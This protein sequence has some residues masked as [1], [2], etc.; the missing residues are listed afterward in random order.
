METE[1]VIPYGD[2]QVPKGYT[3]PFRPAPRITYNLMASSANFLPT[4]TSL[5]RLTCSCTFIAILLAFLAF[6]IS[7]YFRTLWYPIDN[8][9]IATSNNLTLFGTIGRINANTSN[10]IIKDGNNNLT[11]IDFRN[12]AF[13]KNIN[14]GRLTCY[15]PNINGTRY[16]DR[17]RFQVQTA[18]DGKLHPAIMVDEYQRTGFGT[19][20]PF[21][22]VDINGT[23]SFSSIP[24]ISM[25]ITDPDNIGM[26]IGNQESPPNP[27]NKKIK[28][29]TLN[30]KE[31]IH[32]NIDNQ[33]IMEVNS[34]GVDVLGGVTSTTGFTTI[35]DANIKNK[36]GDFNTTLAKEILMQL[37]IIEFTIKK[38]YAHLFHIDPTTVYMG[39][40]AQNA[41]NL[42]PNSVINSEI[43][44]KDIKLVNLNVIVFWLLAAFQEMNK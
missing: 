26:L 11:I 27:P 39:I 33:N 31:T 10:L 25:D 22:T 41:E 23:I 12:N 43:A 7:I 2:Y 24:A 1:S 9:F 13:K 4:P 15:T 37:K 14:V 20:T 21:T 29:I 19:D 16:D 30:S 34:G 17:G 3:S 8:S 5:Q 32:A 35:S 42:I 44:G 40:T 18:L 38:P 28:D 6:I 36:I